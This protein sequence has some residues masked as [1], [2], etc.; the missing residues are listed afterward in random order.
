MLI[1]K[2]RL[3]KQSLRNKWA[4]RISNGIAEMVTALDEAA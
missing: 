4:Y 3:K 1:N 2:P